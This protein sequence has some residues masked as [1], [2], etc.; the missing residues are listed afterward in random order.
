MSAGG[1]SSPGRAAAAD[2]DVEPA[3]VVEKPDKTL[4]PSGDVKLGGAP[5]GER[6]L[7]KLGFRVAVVETAVPGTEG[8]GTVGGG[9]TVTGLVA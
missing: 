1:S 3:A 8:L 2:A 4:S 6:K 5:R 7:C 9:T